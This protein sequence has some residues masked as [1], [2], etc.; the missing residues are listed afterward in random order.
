MVGNG[1]P[2]GIWLNPCMS[3]SHAITEQLPIDCE[4]TNW[5]EIKGS[6]PNLDVNKE[7]ERDFLII[8]KFG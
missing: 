8:V 1:I 6:H 5:N 4:G 3:V 2:Q 7:T